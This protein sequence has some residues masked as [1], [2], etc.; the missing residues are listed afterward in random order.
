[1]EITTSHRS[2]DGKPTLKWVA[3]RDAV[4]YE[5]Y[6][7][8][9]ENG[10]YS[11]VY[12]TTG[13]SYTHVSAIAGK[14]YYY[15][16]KAVLRDAAEV[17]SDIVSNSWKISVEDINIDVIA[18]HREADGKPVLSWSKVPHAVYYQV[19][20]SINENN[21]G[22]VVFTTKGTTYTHASAMEGKLYY[23]KVKAVLKNSLEVYSEVITNSCKMEED[24][25]ELLEVKTGSASDGKP[26][27]TWNDMREAEE[28]VVYRSDSRYGSY[29][30]VFH[31]TGTSYTHVS[32]EAG[33]SYYYKVKTILKDGTELYSEVLSNSYT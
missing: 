9:E 22:S 21:A 23:Y 20:R 31:T 5:V 16:V 7:S 10:S 25:V 12:T 33:K 24:D 11:K 18:N 8:G 19:Y 3:D 17:Y 1:M 13:N 30:K 6:R 32:A 28:Y 2:S 4:F 14:M 26:V 29:A 15:K 27:L